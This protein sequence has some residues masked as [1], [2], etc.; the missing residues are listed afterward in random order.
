MASTEQLTVRLSTNGQVILPKSIRQRRH[1]DAGTR[2]II[3]D[4]ADGVML[5][6]APVFE[7]T[8]P[9]KIFGFL[10]VSG[11]PKSV[12]EMDAGVSAEARRRYARD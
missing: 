10:K 6:A 8:Q 9:G 3:E 4:T 11:P 12:N 7:R 5:K 2:L 1:W